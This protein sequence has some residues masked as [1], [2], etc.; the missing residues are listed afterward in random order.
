MN[1]FKKN[2][3]A[4][5]RGVM[6]RITKNI[7]KSYTDLNMGPI[8][9]NEIKKILISRPNKRLGNLLLIT[10]LLQEVIATFPI[11]K[12]DLFVKGNL[13][14]A[15][16]K[17][18][19]NVD[20]IIQLPEKAFKNLIKYI[21]G[22]VSIKRNHYDLVINVVNNSSSGRLST[23]FANSKYKFFG[24]MNEDVQP[25]Y[26]DSEHMAKFPVYALRT[27][28]MKMGFIQNDKPIP[29]LNLRLSPFEIAEG[30]RKLKKL[31]NNDKKTICL[32]TH[33]TGDKC[34]SAPWWENFYERIKTEY[35]DYSIIE[36]LPVQ[37][38][39]KISF[40]APTFSSKDVREVGS[41]I[42]NTELFICADGGIMHLGSSVHVP[43][44]G[45]F[46]VTSVH[47]YQPYND[48]SV[49]INTNNS[50]TEECIKAINKILSSRASL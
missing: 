5:R 10:P 6:H 31:V 24:D 45:L 35:P 32:F 43:T 29:A 16:F 7:G 44:I 23:Q 39:S 13:A 25:R 18:Y 9:N 50:N 41:L 26:K 30:Q 27:Y 21:Q 22:W 34:Y 11:S 4:L 1:I 15:L 8:V 33:A 19:E 20:R 46:S 12:I 2:I 42:A 48:H 38:T 3:N 28:L 49:G 37:N 40:K 14:P 36:V 47:S 17:N